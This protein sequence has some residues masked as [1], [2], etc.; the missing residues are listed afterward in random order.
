[1]HISLI[2]RVIARVPVSY[3]VV[4]AYNTLSYAAP[5]SYGSTLAAPVYRSYAP[6]YIYK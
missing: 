1:M 6:N 4:P 3:G 2:F 5:I